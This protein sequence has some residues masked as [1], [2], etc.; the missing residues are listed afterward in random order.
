MESCNYSVGFRASRNI[1][2]IRDYRG[3][4][5]GVLF[6]LD[7]GSGFFRFPAT[8][9]ALLLRFVVRVRFLVVVAALPTEKEEDFLRVGTAHADSFR[10]WL[11]VV[12]RITL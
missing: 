5:L 11:L 7:G 6:G 10:I 1:A 2:V 4:G 12:K 9:G 3:V 8:V